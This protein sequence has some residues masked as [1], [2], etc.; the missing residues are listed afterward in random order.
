MSIHKRNKLNLLLQAWPKSTVAV[1]QWLHNLNITNQLKKKYIDSNWLDPVGYGAVIRKGDVVKLEGAIYAMQKQLDLPIHIGGKTALNLKGLGHYVEFG[2]TKSYIFQNPQIKIPSWFIKSQWYI[3]TRFIKTSFLEDSK[4]FEAYQV[5]EEFSIIISSPERAI[6]ECL[7]LVPNEQDIEEA[8]NIMQGLNNLR[9]VLLQELLD[10]C[11][12][13]KVNRLFL[14]L[15]EK[16]NKSW[17]KYLDLKTIEIGKGKRVIVKDGFL[18]T[19]YN[20]TLPISFKK[21]DQ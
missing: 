20:I 12:N 17:F 15:A 8:L 14:Y 18:D 19:K 10:Y 13:I 4:G 9:P 6:L 1:N 21:N 3:L 2:A 7:Y 11:T 16:T 5:S